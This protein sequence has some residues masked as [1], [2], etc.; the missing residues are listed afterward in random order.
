MLFCFECGVCVE[1]WAEC[2][3]ECASVATANSNQH[4]ESENLF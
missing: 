3:S 4:D 2:V 1:C